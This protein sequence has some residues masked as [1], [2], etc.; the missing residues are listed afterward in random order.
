MG[1]AV[2]NYEL[3]RRDKDE[4]IRAADKAH[5]NSKYSSKNKSSIASL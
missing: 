5:Y 1:M 4:F 3:R 2:Y